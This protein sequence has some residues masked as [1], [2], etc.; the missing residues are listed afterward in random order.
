MREVGVVAGV[1]SVLPIWRL[2]QPPSSKHRVGPC[3][4]R[5]VMIRDLSW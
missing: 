4:S 3:I 2:A 5:R 1:V